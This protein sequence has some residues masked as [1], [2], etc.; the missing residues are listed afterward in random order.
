MNWENKKVLVTGADGFIGSHLVELIVETGAQV[1]ALAQYNSFDA[2]GWLDDLPTDI[3]DK[4][5]LARGDI[6]DG[7]QMLSLSRNI[8]VV[9]HLA[10]LIAIPYSYSAPTSY[11]QTNIQGTL[12]LLMAARD[13][14]VERFIHTSTSE[15]YGTAMFTPITEDHPLQGQSPY[16]ASK[17]G[18]DMM[19]EAF[20]RSFGTPVVTLRPFNTY[21]PRQSER[22]VISAIIRQALDENCR[23]IRLGDLSPTRDFN[24]V[25]DTAKAFLAVGE[26]EEKHLGKVFNAGS[27]KMISI[28]DIAQIILNTIGSNKPIIQEENRKRPA[29]S[30]VQ[31][32]LADS[33]RL[34]A[35][36]RWKPTTSLKQG[37]ALTVDWW[38]QQISKTRKQSDFME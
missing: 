2:Y 18:A 36:T 5:K 20:Q 28:G 34:T 4:I 26:I 12:N 10:S 32:L 27:G 35:A 37:L 19:T 22:A 16:S 1:T 3:F 31:T 38:E 11:V 15:V 23:E 29:D 14:G 9:F 21:G 33:S 6:R 24:F 25:K 17:I 30:E 8:D 13:S 7:A